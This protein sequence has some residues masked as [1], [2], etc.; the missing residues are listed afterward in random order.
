[1]SNPGN[2][3][4]RRYANDIKAQILFFRRTWLVKFS[5]LLGLSELTLTLSYRGK[6]LQILISP[7]FF[8]FL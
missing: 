7:E 4:N 8:R 2:G 6:K 1:M 3:E 5:Q